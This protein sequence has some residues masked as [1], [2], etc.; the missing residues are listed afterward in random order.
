VKQNV[1]SLGSRTLRAGVEY[2][3]L[4]FAA[5]FVLG[6]IRTLWVAPAI[7]VRAAELAETPVMI[8]ISWAAARSVVRRLRMPA[9]RG[10]LAATGFVALGLMLAAEFGLVLRLRGMTVAD[11]LASRDAVSGTVYYLALLV[12]AAMPS[13]VRR[14]GAGQQ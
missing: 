9:N 13:L 7:G 8:L 4:V 3:A 10:A 14:R 6:T 1:H 12:F 11:Y 5:G 2:F